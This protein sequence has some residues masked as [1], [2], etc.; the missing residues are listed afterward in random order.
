[1]AYV[2]VI[3]SGLAAIFIGEFVFFWPLLRGAKAIGND[4]LRVLL[5]ES[6]LSP[7][8]WIVGVSL[9]ALF[10]AASRGGTALRVLFF[11]IPT[12][13]VSVLGFSILAT[14]GYFFFAI[15]SRH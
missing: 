9:F 11:W 6:I 3:L 1:M 7:R 13:V 15:A 12:S 14:Y 4:A 5:L 2:K 8:F 10:Y